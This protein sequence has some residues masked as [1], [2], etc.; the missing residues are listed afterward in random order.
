MVALEESFLPDLTMHEKKIPSLLR[1]KY[2][3]NP[4]NVLKAKEAILLPSAES[5][6]LTNDTALKIIS[7]LAETDEKKS[8]EINIKNLNYEEMEIEPI[9]LSVVCKKL[10]DER[11]KEGSKQITTDLLNKWT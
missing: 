7:Y 1:S 5:N 4:F 11:K 9:L 6:I 8:K 2:R 3:L 10:N